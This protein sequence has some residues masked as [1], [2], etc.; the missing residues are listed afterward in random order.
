[1]ATGGHPHPGQTVPP[2]H[3]IG[4]PR[5]LLP[6][7]PRD[8]T[9]VTDPP[10]HAITITNLLTGGRH[11]HSPPTVPSGA[12]TSAQLTSAQVLPTKRTGAGVPGRIIAPGRGS[13]SAKVVGGS[14]G[15]G[16]GPFHDH[17][18]VNVGPLAPPRE[19]HGSFMAE[20]LIQRGTGV[21]MQYWLGGLLSEIPGSSMQWWDGRGR[22]AD[23]TAL[24]GHMKAALT[25]LPTNPPHGKEVGRRLLSTR[26]ALRKGQVDHHTRGSSR[27]VGC[28]L[29]ALIWS[30]VTQSALG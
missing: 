26:T 22:A 24:S 7:G 20:V 4:P 17:I 6:K 5:T 8:T 11:P 12:L 25:T 28:L 21:K 10:H 15:M 9:R 27:S 1:M 16:Q 30:M 13:L 19:S 14:A 29:Q 18:M 23:A 2:Q 3:S